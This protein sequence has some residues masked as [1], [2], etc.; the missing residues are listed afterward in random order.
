LDKSIESMALPSKELPEQALDALIARE[1]TRIVAP[2][3]E[4]RSL[5]V[6]LQQEGLIHDP[7]GG[8]ARGS[9][10]GRPASD[11]DYTAERAYASEAY[12]SDAYASE[13]YAGGP[14]H[15]GGWMRATGRWTM[16]FAAGAA[17]VGVGVVAGR[18][19]TFGQ[20]LINQIQLAISD[21]TSGTSVRIGGKRFSSTREARNTLLRAQ[22]DYQRAA[23]FLAATDSS[24]HVVAAPD[25]YR[26]RLAGLD[27][28][29]TA[30]LNALKDAPQDPLLNEYYLSAV[31]AREATIQQLSS[32]LP[33]GLTMERY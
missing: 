25:V 14:A 10:R 9:A 22:T 31:A 4:W 27:E 28:M 8:N 32:S 21:S 24:P 17:L 26:D 23:A 20:D 29:A 3:T 16:R 30:S 13:A 12:A 5:A 33:V 19:M 2:L 7:A 18:G 1:R 6:S 11:R 15:R